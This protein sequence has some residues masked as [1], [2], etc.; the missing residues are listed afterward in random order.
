M[1]VVT[2]AQAPMTTHFRCDGGHSS[3]SPCVEVE[4]VIHEGSEFE[5]DC[6]DEICVVVDILFSSLLMATK[7]GG[8]PVNHICLITLSFFCRRILRKK[9]PSVICTVSL[10]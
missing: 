9:E 7:K 3:R 8:Q 5:S 2:E 10:Y 4:E 6:L 1:A